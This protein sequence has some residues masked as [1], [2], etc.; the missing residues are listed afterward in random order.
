LSKLDFLVVQD[1]FRTQ[2]AELADVVLPATAAFCESEGTVTN[3]ERRVQRCRKAVPAPDGARDDIEIL[4]EVG[5]RLGVD[6][7]VPTP[8]VAWEELRRVSPM[9]GGMSYERIE[10]LGGIQW[11]CPDETSNGASFLHG[12]LWE[13]PIQGRPAP[14]HAVEWAPVVDMPDADFPMLLTTGRKLDAYNTGVQSA[15][16]GAPLSKREA[17]EL[18]PADAARHGLV[19]GQ[20]VR[21]RSRRGAVE[22]EVRVDPH[23][24]DGLAFMTFHHPEDVD[25][26]QLTTDATDP[27]SGT[28][29][30]KA[31]AIRIEAL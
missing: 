15:A 5:R 23:L 10:A 20:R 24:R 26:N 14:F 12:R 7:G 25:T 11:P 31:A 29:E 16:L 9:H 27:R 13:T 21:V 17:L 22:T 28:A 1:L 30:F 6:L 4:H 19:A 18:S 8:A 3:S 2:T